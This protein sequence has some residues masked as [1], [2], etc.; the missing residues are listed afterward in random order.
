MIPEKHRNLKE[1]TGNQWNM[2]AEI[3]RLPVTNTASIPINFQRFPIGT[4]SGAFISGICC[5][6]K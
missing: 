4:G 1:N 2:E 3:W 5:I 6:F